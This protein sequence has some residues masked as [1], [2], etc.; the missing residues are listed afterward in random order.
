MMK[1]LTIAAAAALLLTAS[2]LAMGPSLAKS[3]AEGTARITRIEKN[4]HWPL[5]GFI[6]MEPCADG[7]CQ[8]V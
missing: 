4:S 6:T 7:R 3:D 5:P 8:E 2:V 1:T